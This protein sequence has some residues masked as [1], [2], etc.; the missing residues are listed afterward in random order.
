MFPR[1]ESYTSHGAGIRCPQGRQGNIFYSG[2]VFYWPV[3]SVCHK[4]PLILKI[5]G[6]LISVKKQVFVSTVYRRS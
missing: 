4:I 1:L 5:D 6:V 2:D 3:L